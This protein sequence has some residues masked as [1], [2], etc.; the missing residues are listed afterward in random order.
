MTG[1]T[2]PALRWRRAFTWVAGIAV[3]LVLALLGYVAFEYISLDRGL[4]RSGALGDGDSNARLGSDVNML[5]MGL[6]SRLDLRGN[7]LPQEL[8]DAMHTGNSSIGAMNANVL[9][10]VHI[11]SDGSRAT[12]IQIPRDNFVTFPGCPGGRCDGKIKE[13][14]DQAFEA[15]KARLS[16]DVTTP[17]EQKHTLAREA[18]RAEEIK[19]VEAFLGNGIRINHFVEV[20]MVAFYQVA[21]VVQ[22]ITVCLKD[23]TKDSYS[24]AD[25]QAGRQTITA[26]QAVAFVRQRRDELVASSDFTDLDRERRQQAFIASLAYQLRQKGTF[27]NPKTINDLVGVA[28]DNIA[29]DN[30]LNLVQF[31]QQATALT[32][33]NVTFFTLPIK[34]YFTDK[35]GGA[36]N[37]VDLPVLQATIRQLLSGQPEPSATTTS[38]AP[39]LTVSVLNGSGV[40]GAG[41][42]LLTGLAKLGYPS[43][44]AKTTP[45]PR[46][47]TVVAYATGQGAAAAELAALLG[48]GVTSVEDPAIEAG[49]LQVTLGQ[50]YQAPPSLG[51]ASGSATTGAAAPG[52]PASA[53]PL[54]PTT[55]GAGGAGEDTAATTLTALFGDGIPC[56]K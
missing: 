50:G 36:S 41:N 1:A 2:P 47:R 54:A 3:V 21:K 52:G 19:T 14:Y 18:G 49:T 55:V 6:D 38:A 26:E 11:P 12:V 39:R 15:E 48:A 35:Y 13:A 34:G 51:D 9:M 44:D 22:P 23:T 17:D 30:D 28:K 43:G 46:P 16:P 8:Y 53:T 31:A 4:R 40:D 10:F 24:G 5:L 33:G 27:A 29:V 56:V 32:S 42:I 37:E 7:P 20:T 25:F 45:V